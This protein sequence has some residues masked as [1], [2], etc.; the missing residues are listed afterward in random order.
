MDS[1]A[2]TAATMPG[3]QRWTFN[4][5][6][7][8]DEQYDSHERATVRTAH[9]SPPAVLG[10][11]TNFDVP[12]G[13]DKECEGFEVEIEDITD[14][15]ITY[16]WP[17]SPGYPN[18]YGNS[19][20]F[21]N[22]TFSNGHTGVIV[23]FVAAYSNGAWS[24]KTPIGQVNHFGIHVNGN[25]GM[26][27]YSWLCDLGGFSTGS[28]GVLTP[29][30]G[31]TQGNFYPIPSVPAVVPSIV[32]TPTGEQVQTTIAP[33]VPPQPA[34]P[35]FQDG[36]W[37]VKYQASSPNAVDVNQLLVTDPEIQNAINNSQIS[38]IAEL[39]Q[40][41]PGTNRGLEQ[42]PPDPIDAGDRASITV[43][44]TY[45]YTGPVDPVDNSITCNETAGDPNNCSNFVGPMIARQMVSAN[46]AAA[47]NRSTLNVN[48]LTGP[49]AST[50]G[51]TVSSSGTANANPGEIDCGASCFTSVDSGTAVALDATANAGYHFDHWSGGCTGSAASCASTVN[52][53]T[54]VNATFVP[55]TPT[56][57]VAD[58]STYEGKTATTHTMKFTVR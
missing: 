50:A 4:L 9:A 48:V 3:T 11:A 10:Y 42:E 55:D 16:T 53:I 51:G 26:Q 40:P 45:Q 30:G 32:A 19:H 1:V 37:V 6:G 29:Y 31:S 58:A 12:N 57:Y 35:Q 21:T 33:A 7:P 20:T 15:Q 52:G 27:R 43:T 8:G 38:S 34:E 25:A 13:T 54:T 17:G 46:L 36:V 5:W 28:T 56:L 18:P 49:I 47:L 39:F 14:T 22:T 41:D 24:A 44:E 23:R 2:P